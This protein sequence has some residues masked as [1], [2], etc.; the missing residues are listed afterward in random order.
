MRIGKNNIV[1]IADTGALF[2]L[3]E[4]GKIDYLKKVSKS[5]WI[6]EAN[7]NEFC[8]ELPQWINSGRPSENLVKIINNS[9]LD[10]TESSGI[11]L[12]ITMKVIEKKKNISII[13]EDKIARNYLTS[14]G[15]NGFNIIS[16]LKLIGYTNKRKGV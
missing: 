7:K 8:N 13:L 15:F 11:A 9:L 2:Y 5:I 14:I 10:Y 4:I 12:A 16:I 1:I 3:N 6:T